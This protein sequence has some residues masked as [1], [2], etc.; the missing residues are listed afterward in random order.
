MQESLE[1]YVMRLPSGWMPCSRQKS[2]QHALPSWIPACPTWTQ[3][4]SLIPVL[5]LPRAT[6]RNTTKETKKNSETNQSRF[7]KHAAEI[8][9]GVL[10]REIEERDGSEEARASIP[11]V[12]L[13]F[14]CFQNTSVLQPRCSVVVSPICFYHSYFYPPNPIVPF[15]LKGYHW[16]GKTEFT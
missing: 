14:V 11:A 13:L 2:S 10:V 5:L 4:I 1:E 8:R 6:E 16:R 3:I 12:F 7:R 15:A 9:W